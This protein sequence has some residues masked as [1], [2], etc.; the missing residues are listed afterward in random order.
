MGVLYFYNFTPSPK[1]QLFNLKSETSEM[2]GGRFPQIRSPPGLHEHRYIKN[3]V[4]NSDAVMNPLSIGAK[5]G[6]DKRANATRCA[7][8]TAAS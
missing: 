4:S 1:E 3:Q 2:T 8:A 7:H 6:R 5:R